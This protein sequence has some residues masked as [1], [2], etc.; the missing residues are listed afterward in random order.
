MRFVV[1]LKLELFMDSPTQGDAAKTIQDLFI[2]PGIVDDHTFTS[3]IISLNIAPHSGK[4]PMDVQRVM[5]QKRVELA[6]RKTNGA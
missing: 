4:V 1:A 3:K 2:C 5:V 6:A